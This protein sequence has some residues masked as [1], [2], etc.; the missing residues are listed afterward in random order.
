MQL[1]YLLPAVIVGALLSIVATPI[2][3][4][5]VFVVI[6]SIG[7]LVAGGAKARY[8]RT[9]SPEPSGRPRPSSSGVTTSNQRQGQD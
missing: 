9:S 6:A 7:V 5:I 3:G 2:V 1:I 4:I 8:T